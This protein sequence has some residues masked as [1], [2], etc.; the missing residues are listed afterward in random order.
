MRLVLVTFLKQ[1]VSKRQ[2]LPI[3]PNVFY[4]TVWVLKHAKYALSWQ[5]FVKNLFMIASPSSW[6]TMANKNR[7]L[8]HDSGQLR[9]SDIY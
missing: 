2:V 9:F 7:R 1:T 8:L 6:S 3:I 5:F 4:H